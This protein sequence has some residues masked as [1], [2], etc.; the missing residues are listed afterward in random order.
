MV[1]L[2]RD[3]RVNI[4]QQDNPPKISLKH[5]RAQVQLSQQELAD[6]SGVSLDT[7][8]KCEQ[9]RGNINIMS[10]YGILNAINR[11]RREMDESQLNLDDL[12]W[13]WVE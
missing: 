12:D 6:A 7:I 10:A 13:K 3:Y 5:A 2:T 4:P 11:I 1:T 9:R 8:R